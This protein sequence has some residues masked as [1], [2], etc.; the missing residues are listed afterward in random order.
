M[1]VCRPLLLFALLQLTVQPSFSFGTLKSTL[2]HRKPNKLWSLFFQNKQQETTF[3]GNSL[4][5][6]N[7]LSD[8]P[9][10]TMHQLPITTQSTSIRYRGGYCE[11]IIAPSAEPASM[12]QTASRRLVTLANVASLLCVIDCT[13]LPI[14]TILF[15]LLGMAAPGQMEWLHEFGHS[16]AIYFVLPGTLTISTLCSMFQRLRLT[17]DP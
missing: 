12:W 3:F 7:I 15:P 11:E 6:Q 10:S 8:D 16:V 17:Y 9:G 14:V 5:L 4:D 1:W 2:H 13:V